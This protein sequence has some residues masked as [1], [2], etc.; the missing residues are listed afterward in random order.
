MSDRAYMLAEHTI[1]PEPSLLFA[2]GHRDIHPLRGL[3]DAGPY[4][5]DLHY[6]ASVKIAYF[7]PRESFSALDGMME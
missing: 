1:L 7:A 4:S 2:D 6:P 5:S 3:T